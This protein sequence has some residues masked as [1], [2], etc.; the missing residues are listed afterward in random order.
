MSFPNVT[1]E[2]IPG[3]KAPREIYRVSVDTPNPTPTVDCGEY[4][5][6]GAVLEAFTWP[7]K[8]MYQAA[9]LEALEKSE[10]ITFS[11][12]DAHDLEAM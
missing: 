12:E 10:P 6:V 11:L 5:T 9:I 2:P 1:I 7:L 3:R 4:A 8:T